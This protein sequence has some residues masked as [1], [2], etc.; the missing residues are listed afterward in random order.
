MNLLLVKKPLYTLNEAMIFNRESIRYYEGNVDSVAIDF[1]APTAD[2]LIVDDNPVNLTVA[3]GLLEPLKMKIDTA[4][5]GQEAISKISIYHYDIIF[6]DHMMP[7]LDGVETTHIIRR[8]HKEYDDVPIIALTANA[9]EGVKEMFLAEGMNDFVP[10]PIE[11]K[12]LISKVKQWLPVEKMQSVEMPQNPVRTT[13]A[14]EVVV[15][16]L[17]TKSAIR[18]LGSEKL[19]WTVLKDY[20]RVIDKKS[21]LIEELVERE[22]WADYTIEVHALKSSSRQIGAHLLAEKAAAMERAGNA[23]N[24]SQIRLCTPSMLLLYRKYASVLKPYFE[25]EKEDD[26]AKTPVSNEELLKTFEEMQ[27][28]LEN[29]DFDRMDSAVNEM[30]KY[31][32]EGYQEEMFHQLKEAVDDMDVDACEEIIDKWKQKLQ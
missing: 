25:D 32:Y 22:A 20:Y 6:M 1:I 9:V 28:A 8:F 24:V 18:L 14:K 27:D 5:T 15:G 7:E 31:S 10:K 2:I 26:S 3:K 11:F 29:L 4:L 13:P 23:R 21:K 17:D 16:D 30:I 12:N 19:F